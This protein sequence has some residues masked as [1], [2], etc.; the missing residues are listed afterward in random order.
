MILDAAENLMAA[1]GYEAT[2]VSALCQASGFPVGSVY[3]H[4]GSKAGVFRAV[5]QRGVSRL[6]AEMATVV[7]PG[8][9]PQERMRLYFERAPELMLRDVSYLRILHRSLSGSDNSAGALGRDTHEFVSA[10]LAEVTEPVAAQAGAS[11]P[12]ALAKSLGLFSSTYASGAVMIA[13]YEKGRL[14][15]IMAPLHD[16]A[17]TKIDAEARVSAR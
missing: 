9:T 13:G 14:E 1:R 12:A 2:S 11:D 15:A 5:M 4:F 3:H 7:P 6:S 16:I 17:R 10:S 8:D